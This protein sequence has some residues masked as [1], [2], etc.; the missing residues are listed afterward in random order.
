MKKKKVPNPHG[1]LGSPKHREKVNEVAK[2]IEKR[3]FLARL[4]YFIQL[5]SGKKRYVDVAAL[6]YNL[7]EKEFHQIGK[8]TKSGIPVK[9]ERDAI[10]EVYQ[11]KGIKPQ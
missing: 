9:R 8:Q 6:D 1:K 4:E 10:E 2:D 11:A 7:D 5:V 3:G